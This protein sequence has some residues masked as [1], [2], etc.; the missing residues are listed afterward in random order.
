VSRNNYLE[1]AVTVL[2]AVGKPLTSR[3]ITREALRRGLIQSAGKT[4]EATMSAHLYVHVRDDPTP[5][6]IRLAEPGEQ[7]A[8]RGTV[9][10]TLRS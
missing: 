10:W 7:R 8:R 5:R 6:V 1:A 9:R 3:E 2:E 4:P